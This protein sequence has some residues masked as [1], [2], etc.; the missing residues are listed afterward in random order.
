MIT[1]SDGATTVTLPVDMLW[2]DE[3]EWQP[4]Q[5]SVDRTITGAL[6][7]EAAERIGGRPITLVPEDE[8]SAWIT[9]ADLTALV[10]WASEPGKVMDLVM[11]TVTRTVVFRHQD[12]SGLSA[13]P[14][15]HYNDI[16][17]ADFFLA[18]IRLMEI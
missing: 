8:S 7:V 18:T 9:L 17:T 13:K 16:T 12:S 11:N 15:V 2:N 6:I 10:A 5:Q 1:L 3:H 4:V 14:L